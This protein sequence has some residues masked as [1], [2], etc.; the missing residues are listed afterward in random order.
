MPETQVAANKKVKLNIEGMTCSNCALSIS[1]YLEKKGA[2]DVLVD[3]TTAEARFKIDNATE[4]PEIKRGIEF[5]GYRVV[6]GSVEE[7]PRPFQ[8]PLLHK[9]YLCLIFTLPL[10][11]HM[12]VDNPVISNPFVQLALCIPV[13]IVGVWHFGKSAFGSLWAGAPNMDV[14]ILLGSSAAFFY[15]LYGTIHN[16]GHDYM[17]YETSATIITIVLLGNLLEHKSVQ[18]TTTAIK[19]L[20]KLR[21]RKAKVISGENGSEQIHEVD[22]DQIK[23][24]QLVLV[25][26][27][28]RIPADGMIVWGECSV[29]ES[30]ISGESTP[31]E[32][33]IGDKLIGGTVVV[34]GSVKVQ[35]EATGNETFLS[36]IIEMVKATQQQKPDIQRLADKISSWFVPAVILVAVATFFISAFFFNLPTQKAIIHSVAVLV[37]A[38]PCAMG[39]A[40]PTAI[41]VGIGMITKKGVLIKGGKTIET[42]S[43]IRQVVFDKTGTLTTGRF[44]IKKIIP[45]NTEAEFLRSLLY[46]LEKHSSH[47]LAQSITRE[48]KGVPELMLR[49]VQELKGIGIRAEDKKGNNLEIGSY[50]IARNLTTDNKHDI[51]VLFNG[52]LIGYVDMQDEIK[53]DAKA[54]IDY[55]IRKRITPILLSGDS[56]QKCAAVAHQLGIERFYFGKQP[57]EKL[58][59][60][61]QLSKQMPTAMVGD[62]INDAPALAKADIGIS[63]SDATEVAIDSAQVILLNG[64]LG[65]LITAMEFSRKIMTTIKQN[66]FWAFFYNVLAIP[67]AAVGLL[68]PMIAAFSMAMSDIFVIGNSLRLKT[69]KV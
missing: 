17:F 38:C 39:L 69:A 7:Q 12:V 52:Q 30:I 8:F 41:M 19:E 67:V 48:L 37:I 58:E 6:D 25:N 63:L 2:T 61:T 55:L 15:S 45:L 56:Y 22:A 32:K 64:N 31:V 51:Y 28:D 16:L 14:L 35:V 23:K 4:L 9:F 20:N 13:Y 43:G 46:S 10:L 27:G 21:V 53:P 36:N 3:F 60:I 68:N 11:L 57:Q 50:S 26:T 29:D 62:G 42:L 54:V 66:L 5:L 59:I 18:Q 33:T 49:N 44:K 65:H 47:P 24:G 34:K 1:K 40:T